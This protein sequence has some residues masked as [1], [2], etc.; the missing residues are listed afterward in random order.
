MCT[1]PSALFVTSSRA[2]RSP[3]PCGVKL[4]VAVQNAPGATAP[5]VDDARTKSAALTPLMAMPLTIRS[6]L[7]PL[8]S[9]TVCAA[10]VVP[11]GVGGK[12]T[13]L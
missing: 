11:R 2:S 8:V 5:H 6:A 9:V 7:P 3:L 13:A 12:G 10:L 1:L 4:M